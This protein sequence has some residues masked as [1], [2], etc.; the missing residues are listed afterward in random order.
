MME[1]CSCLTYTNHR[2]LQSFVCN[3]VTTAMTR[4]TFL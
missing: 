4:P 2:N 1:R 3:A